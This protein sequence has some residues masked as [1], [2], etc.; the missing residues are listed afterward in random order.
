VLGD[1]TKASTE[2]GKRILDMMI[3]H[4]VEFI[5]DLKGMTLEEIYQKRY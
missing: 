2:K 5:E 3:S 4:L 1:P